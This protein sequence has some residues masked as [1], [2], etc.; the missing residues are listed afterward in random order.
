MYSQFESVQLDHLHQKQLLE[1]EVL[2][3][4]QVHQLVEEG[5]GVVLLL[6]EEGIVLLLLEAM[7]RTAT[8]TTGTSGGSATTGRGCAATIS[9]NFKVYVLRNEATVDAA[10]KCIETTDLIPRATSL[11]PNS[12]LLDA[13][14][15]KFL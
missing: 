14:Q 6:E 9:P 13:V 12:F 3:Q 1:E 4:L 8:T 5:L 2:L 10:E 15:Q 11:S 7:V